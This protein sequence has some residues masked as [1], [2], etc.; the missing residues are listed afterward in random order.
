MFRGIFSVMFVC[1]YI[2][3]TPTLQKI[4]LSDEAK[5]SFNLSAVLI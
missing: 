2:T 4:Y 3:S 1:I 5:E